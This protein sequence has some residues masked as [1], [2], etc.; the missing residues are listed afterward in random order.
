[1]SDKPTR[2]RLLVGLGITLIVA[3]LVAPVIL[4]NVAG[5]RRT[6]AIEGLARAPVGCDTTLDFVEAG[7]YIVFLEQSGT[8][9][10][11]R[12]DCDVDGTFEGSS[13]AD[14]DVQILDPDGDE[15]DLT[16]A[17]GDVSYDDAGFEGT[18][19]FTVDIDQADDHVIRV[20]SSDDDT[21]AVAV[22]RDP[23]AGVNALIAG[24]VAAAL[25]GLVGGLALVL[26]GARRKKVAPVGTGGWNNAAAPSGPTYY[27]QPGQVPQGPPVYGQPG[28]VGPPQFPAQYPPQYSPQAPGQYPPQAP[29][30]Y[31][32]Q[33]P[34]QY[35]Q[36]APNQ[37]PQSFGQQAQPPSWSTPP[38]APPSPDWRPATP[39]TNSDSAE[40]GQSASS[41]AETVVPDADYLARLEAERN[42][43][44]P[45]P[46]PT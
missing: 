42:R 1:M 20:E 27:G 33:A 46:P 2:R 36:Q 21:Y 10:Q 9:D 40:W 44:Q 22:G 30:Q 13:S 41:P 32:P 39:Q 24:A 19:I 8:I 34:A 12:G 28:P 14:P 7:T 43:P 5:Q 17:D 38:P 23:N 16:R 29:A 6:N 18:S 45:P 4:W 11:V 25:V 31:P 15:V 35:P 3:G 37:Y 26:L